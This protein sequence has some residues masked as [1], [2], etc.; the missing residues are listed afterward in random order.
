MYPFSRIEKK[1]QREWLLSGIYEPSLKRAK[2]PF[3]NLMMFPYPSAEGLH[4]GN[5]YAFAGTDIYGRMKRMQGYD[6]FE[7]IGLDGFGIH[8]ENYAIKIGKHPVDQAK[9]SEKNF[10]RQ[11]EMIGNGFAWKERLETYDPEYYKWTQW[12]FTQMFRHGLAYRKKQAV[13]WCPSCKTVLADEQV[14]AGECERCCS[15]IVKKE[16]EQWFLRITAYAGK[17]LKNLD[18]I[19]WSEKVKTAQRNWIG[20]SEGASLK[21]PISNSQFSIEAFTTRPD[22]LFGATYI[23][24]APEHPLI[25]KLKVQISNLGEVE[26]Y[27]KKAH[28]KSESDRIAEQKEKTGV[29]LKGIKAVNPATGDKIPVWVADYVVISYGTG[30]IMAVPAH[31]ERDFEFAKK[32]KLPIV[33]VI[34]PVLMRVPNPAARADAAV[35]ELTI[36][37]DLWEGE[38]EMINSGKFNGMPSEKARWE[39][40]KFVAGKKQTQYHLRD[41]LISRQRYWGPPIPMIFCE[42]CA[43]AGKGERENTPGW[44]VVPEE[45]LPV[46]LPYLKDFRPTG[47]GE[48][49]LALVES[50]YKVRCPKCKSWA[51]RETDVSDTFLD[52]AWYYL[53]YPSADE[54]KRPWNAVITKKWL[55]VNIYIGGAEHSVLHLLYVRFIAMALHDAGLIAF[56]E[57]FPKF[58]AH[59][60][61]IKDGAK[62]SKSRGNVVNPDEYIRNFGAD[63]LRMYLVFL[64]PFEDGGDFRD[65]G[66]QGI[67]RF[68]NR[69]WAFGGKVKFGRE[70][71]E[72]IERTLHRTI[73][74]VTGDIEN[75][76][77]NTAISA[78]MVLLREFENYP[79]TVSKNQFGLFLKLLAPF[80]PHLSEE[81]W[82]TLGN[83]NSI[84]LES[85]PKYDSKLLI[86]DFVDLVVQ[87]NGKF[88]AVV[89]ARRGMGQSEAEKLVLNDP[90]VRRVLEG[91]K[92]RKVIF[93]RD[94]LINFV[95]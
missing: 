37:G 85:W 9:V 61:I 58:R 86:E 53:R 24:L 60:L 7:P 52:S 75:L 18:K 43:A 90:K 32:F 64:G 23:V 41:W 78:L 49:P 82:R 79:T 70:G 33:K 1:W 20:K 92:L 21:F 15:T 81:L 57:P 8:S 12:I 40:T 89:S 6:V 10:Y 44:Y 39:I 80:A 88:R 25:E 54:K 31:D 36:G 17:L 2:K 63:A 83:K 87:V 47:T 46:K 51:R 62:M 74:K 91:S 56:E 38:G 35:S 4:V 59:G 11:L 22:T 55:P 69:V 16:L 14:I 67:T 26:K 95:T 34:N 42:K 30:A 73:K 93:I 66:I 72:A 5:V 29:E 48:S 27:I 19:D 65:A 77:Y 76:G 3:Y 45:D 28:L 13:N 68:L 84:H 50:F 94:R 71:N